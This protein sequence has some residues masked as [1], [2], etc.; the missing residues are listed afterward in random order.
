MATVHA[1]IF[2]A[3]AA[4]VLLSH[5]CVLQGV[6]SNTWTIDTFLAFLQTAICIPH[7]SYGANM[8]DVSATRQRSM[9]LFRHKRPTG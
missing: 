9:E 3:V 2:I 5:C 4:S 7:L 1:A 6:C 8:A